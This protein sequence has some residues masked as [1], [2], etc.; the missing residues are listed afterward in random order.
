MNLGLKGRSALITGASKGIGRSIAMELAS[1]GVNLILT[2]RS[3]DDLS[4]VIAEIGSLSDVSVKAFPLNLGDSNS[5]ALLGRECGQVDILV[6]NAGAIPAGRIDEIDEKCWRAAWDLKVFGYINMTRAFYAQ[7]R[8]RGSGVIINIIGGAGER[9]NAGYICGSTG[10]AALMAFTRTL[11][12][13]SH[14]DGV[15]VLGINPGPVQTTRHIASLRKEAINRYGDPERWEELTK[16]LPFQRAGS[17]AEI[18]HMVAFLASNLSAYTTG[19]IVTID[20]G[21][22]N[23]S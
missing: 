21:L 23:A 13:A 22:A 5:V 12:G 2:A 8:S 6:N 10:N 19:T 7:M 11:G 17:S 1:E 14:K 4:A 3:A 20:G 18:A 15:R 9:L 16:P